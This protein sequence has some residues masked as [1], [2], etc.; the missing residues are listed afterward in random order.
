MPVMPKD[1]RGLEELTKS[2]ALVLLP[3]FAILAARWLFGKRAPARRPSDPV[4]LK[5]GDFFLECDAS[6]NLPG[7]LEFLPDY[8]RNVAEV[9][10]ALAVREPVVIDVGANIGD[11]ALLLAGVV[12]GVRVL[13]VEGNPRFM[14]FLESNTSQISGVTIA[15]AVLSDRTA[16]IQGRF[17][18]HGGT[19]HLV[20]SNGAES[21]QT[22]TLDD[23][24]LS[25][26]A[27]ASPHL[28]KIDTDGFDA[29][30][31]RGAKG[32]LTSA[33]PVVFYEWD[34]YSYSLAGENDIGHAEFLT[35]LGFE[36][37]LIFDNRGDLLLNVRRP[38]REV[39]ESLAHF[40][41]RRHAIDGLYYDIA[42]FP[43]ERLATCESVWQHYAQSV[44]V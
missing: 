39:W 8:G 16:L 12:P 4:R 21:V 40:S 41:R 20:V 32:V 7:I 10:R 30:I 35:E 14:P 15:S 11:T 9:A 2:L 33:R 43:E 5:Y 37:F 28:I 29:P 24:L 23:L 36:R 3:P 6:H 31:L 38:G 44:K 26:P 42:A 18:E 34:P 1:V 25:Y 22:H 19:A 17:N 27:F 13:C